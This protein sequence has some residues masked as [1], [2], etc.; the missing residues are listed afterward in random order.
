MRN[1][2]II[3]AG[4]VLGPD[5][6]AAHPGYSKK[7]C[8]RYRHSDIQAARIRVK[9][10]DY[11][12]VMNEDF[13]AAFT[14][15]DLG[16]IRMASVSFFDFTKP[17][18]VTRTVL[19]PPSKEFTMPESSSDGSVVFKT[20]DLYLNFEPNDDGRLLRCVFRRF[21]NGSDFRVYIQ[22]TDIPDESMTIT[23]PWPESDCFYYN[24]KINCMRAKGVVEYN[25]IRYK[26]DPDKDAGVLDWG[27]GVWPYQSKCYWGTGSGYLDDVPFGFNLGYGFGDTSKATEN[28]VYY[29][30]KANKLDNIEF[31][32]PPDDIMKPWIITSS[33]GR[34]E[35]VFTPELNR[36]SDMNLGLIRSDQKQIFGNF[37]GSVILDDGTKLRPENFRCAFEV[38]ENRY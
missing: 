19:E 5:G 33:D 17:G 27:R 14:V 23:T 3:T 35:G 22:F 21:H 6:R 32:I 25:G 36:S 9:E 37:K 15:S 26:L 1:T 18:D 7:P 31:V 20:E 38:V 11:Y 13:G 16:Y 12:L 10:W 24:Q 2:E 4:S 28:M 34:F 29:D 8:L 30:G